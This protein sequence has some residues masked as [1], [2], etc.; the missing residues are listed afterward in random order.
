M[1][2]KLKSVGV[3]SFANDVFEVIE[4]PAMSQTKL[5]WLMESAPELLEA[6]E[7]IVDA[8]TDHSVQ[9]GSKAMRQTIDV[10]IATIRKAK[11]E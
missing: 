3:D 11:G 9:F 1:A 10:G 7:N 4:R 6:L 8:Y 5:Q 2:L